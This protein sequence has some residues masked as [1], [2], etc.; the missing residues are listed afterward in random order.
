L[1]VRDYI[2]NVS[3]AYAVDELAEIADVIPRIGRELENLQTMQRNAQTKLRVLSA[4]LKDLQRSM[5]DLNQCPD[6]ICDALLARYPLEN[7][8][9]TDDLRNVS[10][11]LFAFL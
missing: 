5:T 11:T 9:V 10:H 3:G 8:R 4:G 6:E 1:I 2:V 7:L